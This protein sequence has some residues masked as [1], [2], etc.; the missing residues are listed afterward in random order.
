MK[1]IYPARRAQGEIEV[2]GDKSIS[3]R[4]LMLAAIAEGR[5]I[6]HNLSDGNDVAHT[7][8]C[9]EQLGVSFT[10]V[11]NQVKVE[12]VGLH[13]L[14][15]PSKPLNA[16]NSG[17]TM[18]LLS[19]ILAGQ[20]FSS[21]LTG[22]ASL[23]RRPMGR[24]ITPLSQM[25][26]RFTATAAQ[27]APLRIQGRQL[28]GITYRLPI[29]S[30]QVK[31]AILFA[32]LYAEGDTTVIEPTPSRNH[33]ELMFRYYDIPITISGGQITVRSHSFAAKPI[34]IPGD[35]SSAAYFIVLGL[36]L[37][38]SRLVI[39]NV[40]LN[41][42]RSQMLTLLQSAGADI[43]VSRQREKCGELW[44]DLTIVS[45]EIQPFEIAGSDVPL[46][47][48][49]IPALA[50]LATRA[51]GTTL[52]RNAQ[53]LR[54]KESDRLEAIYKNLVKMGANVTL[55]QDGMEI[56]GP[57]RLKGA[58][59]EHFGDHRIALAFTI[60]GLLA[61]G[62]THIKKERVVDISFPGFFSLLQGVIERK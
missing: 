36:A 61:E 28:H 55:Y 19:G 10:D 43:S 5:S 51:N 31:S 18:R 58:K 60:A 47:I 39:R 54:V 27:T 12:G 26:A 52:I 3:H 13:G 16:G 44:G 14:Q 25:G 29:A 32:G 45:S 53:E 2:P 22:D 30:A 33:T 59:I 38:D 23:R 57:T 17:T 50:V 6:I 15:P 56:T 7:R 48:D 11:Q 62:N 4:A 35:F 42:T 8:S 41:P 46:L 24:I 34:D 49:E 37:P 21:I 40:N 1:T 20:P 9:L